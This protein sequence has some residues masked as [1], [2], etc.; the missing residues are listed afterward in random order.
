MDE[1]GF[2]IPFRQAL[3]ILRSERMKDAKVD[4]LA[5]NFAYVWLPEVGFDD[6]KYP[7]PYKRSLWIRLPI[8]F[9]FANPHGIVTCN[10]L[11]PLDNH[12]IKGHNPNHN[13]CDPVKSLGGCHYYSWTWNGPE[14]GQGPTL[15][16]PQ[17]IIG[18]VTWIERRIKLA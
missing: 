8:Q 17:D 3:D 7:P 4:S 10:P 15:N 18:V 13:M 16:K 5:T 9:P 12:P 6:K 14:F 1:S 2:P 11:D